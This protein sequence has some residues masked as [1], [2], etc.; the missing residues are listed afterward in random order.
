VPPGAPFA[1]AV[2][3]ARVFPVTLT[4]DDPGVADAASLPTF[5]WQRSGANGGPGPVNQFGFGGEFDKRITD[6]LGIDINDA[7]ILQSVANGTNQSGWQDVS[8]TLKYQAYVNA[9]DFLGRMI[10]VVELRFSTPPSRPNNL[11][12]QFVI[13]PGVV[14]PRRSRPPARTPS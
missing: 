8:A 12:T 1:H 10:P 2:A 14:S 11:G 4:I 9:P 7:Y 3:G 5:T 13:V 6:N